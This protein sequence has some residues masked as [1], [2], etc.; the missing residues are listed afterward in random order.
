MAQVAA[1]GAPVSPGQ[2]GA[3][4]GYIEQGGAGAGSVAQRLSHGHH[5]GHEE[6]AVILTY[7]HRY[8]RPLQQG[9]PAAR[10]ALRGAA[11]AAAARKRK[12][13]GRVSVGR[14]AVQH[15]HRHRLQ[16]HRQQGLHTQGGGGGNRKYFSRS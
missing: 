3:G 6:L 15:H 14:G 7:N 11:G 2:G 9:L 4:A 8:L 1:G 12:L 13:R 10:A 16:L 5:G